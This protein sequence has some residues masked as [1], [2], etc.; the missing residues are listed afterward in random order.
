MK[1]KVEIRNKPIECHDDVHF[2][3]AVAW[4]QSPSG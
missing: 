3:I 1:V 2:S 4:L